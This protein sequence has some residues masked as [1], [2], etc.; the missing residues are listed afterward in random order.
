MACRFVRSVVAFWFAAPRTSPLW[1]RDSFLV[2]CSVLRSLLASERSGVVKTFRCADEIVDKSEL[3]SA[4]LDL[5]DG[6][7][8]STPATATQYV[9]PPPPQSV[10]FSPSRVDGLPD[11]STV[12]VNATQLVFHTPSGDHAHSF[13][14]IGR[15][16]ESR[17]ASLLKRCTFRR[18][19]PQIV[20]NRSWCMDPLRAYFVFYTDPNV[21]I[22]MPSGDVTDYA[23]CC[24]SRIRDIIHSGRYATSD[25]N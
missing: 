8:P 5:V 15:R 18:P 13:A 11:V 14:S 3:E 6:K 21:T 23:T 16:Q 7:T 17:I 25:L 2:S 1:Q 10:I 20:A 12:T 9:A 19:W 24:F 22:Y 4:F